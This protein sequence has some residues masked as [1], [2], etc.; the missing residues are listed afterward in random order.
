LRQRAAIGL[1]GT[2]FLGIPTAGLS[3]PSLEC[4]FEESSQIEISECL[5]TTRER[6]ELAMELVL[7]YARDAAFDLDEITGREVA[8][9]ALEASQDAWLA[10]REKACAFKGAQSGGGSGTGIAI[11]SCEIE[12]T[13]ARTRD[14]YGF[15]D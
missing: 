4:S 7:G 15:F 11:R 8:L 3:Q 13:R 14:L 1:A 12:M 5:E 10:F 6:V 9:P 2:L